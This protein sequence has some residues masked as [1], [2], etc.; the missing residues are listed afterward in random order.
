[1]TTWK[2]T[3]RAIAKRLNGRRLGATGGATPDVITD[4]LAVE[5]K[6]RKE[7]PGWLKDA[8]AQA[9]HNA[10]ER[11]PQVVLHEAGKRHADDLILLRMQDLERLL[12]KQF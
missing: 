8:L 12:S 6:H 1:M 9:V 2:H 5:V 10:G 4:R 11:L 7:L 3:E